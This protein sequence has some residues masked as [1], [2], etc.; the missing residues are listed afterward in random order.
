MEVGETLEAPV[1]GGAVGEGEEGEEFAPLA[2][3]LLL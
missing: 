3:W 2:F 1:A